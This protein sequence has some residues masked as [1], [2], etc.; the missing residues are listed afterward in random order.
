MMNLQ[1]RKMGWL[2]VKEV[3]ILV[4][5]LMVL[6]EGQENDDFN[7]S[8]P[9]VMKRLTELANLRVSTVTSNLIHTQMAHKATFCVTDP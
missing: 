3:C 2:R 5:I 9:T 4:M 7:T 8:D 6:V 1:Q